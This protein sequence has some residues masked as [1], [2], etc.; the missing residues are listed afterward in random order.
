M[1]LPMDYM[2]A[3]V[4]GIYLC[5]IHEEEGIFHPLRGAVIPH[6]H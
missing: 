6:N 3:Y 1:L 2:P 4:L 5:F